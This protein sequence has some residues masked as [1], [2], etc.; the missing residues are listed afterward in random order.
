MMYKF[1]TPL[2]DI[3]VLLMGH[4]SLL[5]N[6][7][8]RNIF[9][10]PY[11]NVADY[12]KQPQADLVLLTHHHYDHL[13]ED[14]L[15]HIVNEKTIFVTSGGCKGTIKEA[16]VIAPGMSFNY[17][18]I[19]IEAVYAYNILNRKEDGEPFHPRGEGNG[20]ILNFGGYRVY[21]A[22]DT[23]LIPEMRELGEIDLA[24]LPKNLP[25]TMS[26]EM[27]IEAVKTIMPKNL[28]AYHYFKIDTERLTEQ[29]PEGVHFQNR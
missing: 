11:S 26:D 18:D 10:D 25:Y 22:G 15:K 14:A 13:D 7:Q 16:N 12:S 29:M 5:I 8:E 24:F 27:F 2:G 28:F 9:V 17:K 1:T 19:T 6:W 3:S 21:I 4:A 23:E 20:Y